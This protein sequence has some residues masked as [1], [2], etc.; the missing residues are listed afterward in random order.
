MWASHIPFVAWRTVIAIASSDEE[1]CTSIQ[2]KDATSQIA[3]ENGNAGGST[4][5]VWQVDGLEM[6]ERKLA[7]TS[8]MFNFDLLETDSSCSSS[9]SDFDVDLIPLKWG[10][11]FY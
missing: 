4:G 3:A 7:S 11:S 10:H 1:K 9:D 2:G 6:L 8:P 5:A